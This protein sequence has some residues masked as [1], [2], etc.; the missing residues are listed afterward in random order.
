NPELLLNMA[1]CKAKMNHPKEALA[2]FR[3]F[4]RLRPDDAENAQIRGEI[5]RLEQEANNANPATPPATPPLTPTADNKVATTPETPRRRF[6]IIGTALAGGTALFIVFGGI[7]VGV[8]KSRFDNLSMTCKPRCTDDQVGNARTAY[9]AGY[10][11]F[12]LAAITAV[13]AGVVLPYE[14]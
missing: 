1:R 2:H 13:A 11:M 4:L 6:P 12:G 8:G 3:E 10:A 14:L 7:A 5:T 9:N